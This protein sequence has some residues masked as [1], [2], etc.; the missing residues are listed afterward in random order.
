MMT[1]A[2]LTIVERVANDF[3]YRRSPGLDQAHDIEAVRSMV[4]IV[5]VDLVRICPGRAS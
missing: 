4:G 5:A 3:G 1:K 2:Q